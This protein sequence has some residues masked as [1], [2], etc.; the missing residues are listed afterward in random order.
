MDRMGR[1]QSMQAMCIVS[2]ISGALLAAS[3]NSA[4][5]T[6]FRFFSGLGSWALLVISKWFHR[7]LETV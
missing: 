1:K 4:M 6:I 3:Q 5:F 7:R 2:M